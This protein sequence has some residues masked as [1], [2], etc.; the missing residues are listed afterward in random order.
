M[1]TKAVRVRAH[2]RENP[3]G[4][5]E[6]VKAHIRHIEGADYHGPAFETNFDDE[7]QKEEEEQEESEEQEET[8]E[9]KGGETK[10]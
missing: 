4:G 7:D 9:S 8:K 3:H 10:E 5:T 1:P 2:E 6:H